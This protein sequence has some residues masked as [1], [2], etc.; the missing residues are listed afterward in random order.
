MLRYDII[1]LLFHIIRSNRLMYNTII[2][3]GGAT[4]LVGDPSGR[5]KERD[6]MQIEALETNLK[7]L[8]ENLSR[9][10]SNYESLDLG[11]KSVGSQIRY[12]IL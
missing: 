10:F 8:S 5:T 9:I 6:K 1:I 7:G 4:G 3:I 11:N 12:D 2:Q